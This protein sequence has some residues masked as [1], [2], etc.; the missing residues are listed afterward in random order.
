MKKKSKGLLFLGIYNAIS[1]F[2][3]LF[4]A[5]SIFVV[6]LLTLLF[7]TH[8]LFVMYALC[9]CFIIFSPIPCIV[10]IVLGIRGWIKKTGYALTCFILSIIGL[11]LFTAMMR[12]LY[13]KYL[14]YPIEI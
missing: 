3:A 6:S 9:F 5:M 2:S 7:W 4:F 8:G 10:G 13:F 1:V 14:Y 12:Y 11:L